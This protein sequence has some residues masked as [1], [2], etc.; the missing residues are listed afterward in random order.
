MISRIKGNLTAVDEEAAYIDTGGLVYQVL[1]PAAIVAPLQRILNG[2]RKEVDFHTI[3]YIE[4]GF[5]GS[6]MMPRLVGFLAEED[7]EFF[8]VFITVKGV[9]V[10]KAL[11]AFSIPTAQLVRAIETGN[12]TML[13][14]LPEIGAR[15]AERMIAELKGKLARFAAAAEARPEAE[16]TPE[17]ELTEQ[18]RQI[19][20]IQLQY[21]AAEADAMMSKALASNKNIKT[22]QQL[23][24]EVFRLQKAA[25]R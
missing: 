13:M 1:V 7:R 24:G 19:L 16:P 4:G 2:P 9:G 18:A 22:V 8:K 3:H 12:R 15:T 10:R 20:M 17:T 6:H 11:R 21:T 5:N 14:A 25:G 23:L